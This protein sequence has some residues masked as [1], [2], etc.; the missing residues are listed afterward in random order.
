[1]LKNIAYVAIAAVFCQ[2]VTSIRAFLLAKWISPAEYGVWTGLNLIISLAPIAALGTVEALVKEVAFYRGKGDKEKQ[3][4]VENCVFG[5]VILAGAIVVI[6][7]YALRQVGWFRFFNEHGRLV[8]L[9]SFSVALLAISSLY[10]YRTIANENF[11]L[12]GLLDTLRAIISSVAI[13]L[14]G[15]F[16]GLEGAV[17]GLLVSE[18]ILA[19]LLAIICTRDQGPARISFSGTQIRSAIRIGLP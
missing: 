2:G 10:Y 14:L 9:T 8:Q 6:T 17:F 12:V 13:L 5:S 3:S 18:L 7:C 15:N 16:F 4:A 1:M 19:I 11:Q